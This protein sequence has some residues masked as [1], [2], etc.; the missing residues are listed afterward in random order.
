MAGAVVAVFV[1]L[2]VRSSKHILPAVVTKA[3]SNEGSLSLNNFE[4]RDVKEGTARW[5]VW[6]TTATYFEDKQETALDQVKALFFLINGG[7]VLL[8]GDRG[9]LHNDTQNMEISG[10]VKVSYGERYRLSTD[11]L[12]YNRDKELIHTGLP[13]LLEGEGIILKG[14]GMRLEIKKRTLSV[15]N[16]IETTLEG[17]VSFGGQRPGVSLV[18]GT[19]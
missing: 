7:E 16:H 6:A 14:Q 4:Y 17:I 9:V 11:R 18:P 15:L 10:N 19:G 12:L 13:I 3:A 1:G 5:T 8:T 2:K